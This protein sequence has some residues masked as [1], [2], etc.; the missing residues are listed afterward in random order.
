MSYEPMNYMSRREVL[1][2]AGVSSVGLAA[3]WVAGCGGGS[4]GGG[5][6]ERIRMTFWGDPARQ[7]L[8][9][10]ATDLFAKHEPNASVTLEATPWNGYWDKLATQMAGRSAADWIMMDQSFLG[11]YAERNA[12]VDLTPF[13]GKTLDLSALPQDLVDAAKIDGK[14]FVVPLALNSQ[15][16]LYNVA[17]L[18]ELGVDLPDG[19]MTWD[20][21]GAF[22]ADVAEASGGKLAGSANMGWDTA[23]L[24]VWLR[25]QGKELYAA[26]GTSLALTKQDL[27]EWWEYWLALQKSGAA[28]AADIQ[29]AANAGTDADDLVVKGHAATVFNWSPAWQSLEQLTQD[30]IAGRMLPFGYD[31]S[32]QF[33]K[34]ACY[35]CSPTSSDELEIATELASFIVNDVETAKALG[36]I[37][38]VPVSSKT[39][40]AVAATVKGSGRKTIEYIKEVQST[41]RPQTRPWPKG[42][43]GVT[44]ALKRA[45]E[46]LSFGRVQIGDAADRMLDEGTQALQ[47]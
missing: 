22:A 4:D 32:G 25:G 40:A 14:L 38:G 10:K 26:D 15:I 43:G 20:A 30:E 35:Y 2:R 9:Q 12:L 11:E 19:E 13:V 45:Y 44:E 46:N 31:G 1:R 36:L 47:A 3:L 39:Q 6:S 37:L 23:T 29:A 34:P 33:V 42:A 28:V 17:A 16:L 24:E 18:R 41:A 5:S 27:Q 7:E 21:F 8:M